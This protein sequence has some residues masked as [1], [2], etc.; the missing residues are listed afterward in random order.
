MWK[1]SV[2]WEEEVDVGRREAACVADES[3]QGFHCHGVHEEV[4][5]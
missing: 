4:L 5:Q 1:G 3:E 2:V